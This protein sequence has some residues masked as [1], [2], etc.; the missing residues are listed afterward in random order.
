MK[1]RRSE[2]HSAKQ[3]IPEELAREARQQLQSEIGILEGWL[4]DLDETSD[5]NPESITA[6][7]SYREMLQNRQELLNTLNGK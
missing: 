6:R 2:Q 7:E 3:P 4:S 1:D 5:D